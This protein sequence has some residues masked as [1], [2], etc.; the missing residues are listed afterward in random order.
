MRSESLPWKALWRPAAALA[1]AAGLIVAERAIESRRFVAPARE[2]GEFAAWLYGDA[3]ESLRHNV[4]PSPGTDVSYH[5]PLSSLLASRLDYHAH[6]LLRRN[7][8]RLTNFAKFGLIVLLGTLLSSPAAG[9]VGAVLVWGLGLIPYGVEY[10]Q[11]HYSLLVSVCAAALAWYA[12]RPSIRRS[13]TLG[14]AVGVSLLFRSPLA[15]LP[16]FW[17]LFE[18]RRLRARPPRARLRVI[19]PALLLSYGF[20]L[21]WTDMNWR[22][23]GRVVPVENREATANVV[24]GALGMLAPIEGDW[25]AL[26]EA[27]PEDRLAD[28]LAWAAGE[29][30]RHP[31]RYAKAVLSRLAYASSLH[32]LLLLAA[33]IALWRLRRRSGPALLGGMAFYFIAA[34]CLM[35]VRPDFF[36]PLWPLLAALVGAALTEA[37]L[38]AGR[39]RGRERA[40]R[41]GG[42]CLEIA[43]L[44]LAAASLPA[45]RSVLAYRLPR[46]EARDAAYSR[47]IES[48]PDDAWLRR[49]RGRRRLLAGD[50]AGAE[51]DYAH[52]QRLRPADPE[53]ELELAWAAY[54]NGDP[55]ALEAYRVRGPAASGR[56][57]FKS[58]LMKVH[59]ALAQRKTQEARYQLALLDSVWRYR[60]TAVLDADR[61]RDRSALSRLRGTPSL[62]LH[63][64]SR[65]LEE[66]LPPDERLRFLARLQ[67]LDTEQKEI[68]S[69]A[70]SGE[71]ARIVD[72][73]WRAART[74][75]RRSALRLLSAARSVPLEPE[76]EH[77]LFLAYQEMGEY[78]HARALIEKLIR[79][80]PGRASLHSDRGV[81]HYLNGE[82]ELAIASLRRAIRLDPASPAPYL[83]LGAV[84][85]FQQRYDKAIA[86]YDLG[87]TATRGD[88]GSALRVRIRRSRDEILSR[89]QAGERSD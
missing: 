52:A 21:P 62:S 81:C 29:I 22:L 61:S 76:A 1:L 28:V 25:R 46:H 59:A 87:L 78:G 84:Y 83:S 68:W 56:L 54:R 41:A 3:G 7:W 44:A 23:H 70:Y 37:G 65:S 34:H 9:V 10:V 69:R 50:F 45:V 35:T 55:S 88:R 6:P 16:P 30:A 57:Q 47:A 33:V 51:T 58:L 31:A 43:V 85:A 82:P 27:P 77:K 73:A 80:D 67:S 12:R 40:I 38:G 11:F 42:R 8:G 48:H 75:R 20:L 26:V 72:R 71:K 64:V 66:A 86:V 24:T 2:Q 14:A 15:F 18:W 19:L 13:L 39:T 63:H 17:A 89:L 74:G 32:P 60:L 36:M 79:K 5:M 49:Q 53:I 4:P